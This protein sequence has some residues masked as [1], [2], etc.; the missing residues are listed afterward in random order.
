MNIAYITNLGESSLINLLSENFDEHVVFGS[1]KD[2]YIQSKK[3]S[4]ILVQGFSNKEF[5]GFLQ[6]I[7]KDNNYFLTP[8]FSK[9]KEY[10]LTCGNILNIEQC[11]EKIRVVDLLSKELTVKENLDWKDR[12]LMYLYTRKETILKPEIDD[13]HDIFYHYPLIEI[14]ANE[15]DNY[16]YY[17][18]SLAEQNV[19]Q[20]TTLVDKLFCCPKCF[21]AHLK[22]TDCCPNCNSINIKQAKF[23]HCFSCGFVAPEEKFEK[24]SRFVC[25]SC[26]AKLK[27]IGEDYD[28]PLES[29]VCNDCE[30]YYIDSK[31]EVTC[32]SEMVKLSSEDL[33]KRSI[34]EYK[35]TSFGL[36][37]IKYGIVNLTYL[38]V[39]DS[40]Y[41][42]VE[43]FNSIL[44]WFI[45]MNLRYQDE[46]FSMIA[47]KV[48]TLSEHINYTL[49]SELSKILRNMHRNTD[50]VVRIDNNIIV[51]I[52]PKVN[53]DGVNI[54]KTRLDEFSKSINNSQESLDI[55]IECFTSNKENVKDESANTLISNLISKL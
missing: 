32:I 41:V 9:E 39:D 10:E 23:I 37:Q 34:Y 54:I 21:S 3:F 36:N 47:I 51:F 14:F 12:F 15:E 45:Q 2:F 42:S 16:F 28:R 11:K 1:L 7:R 31:I 26:N 50:F 5:L 18:D 33:I 4:S 8:V 35:L 55:K 19:I 49:L 43:Y 46:I 53:S 27:L 22:F 30:E 6:V 24:N 29:G 13:S 17:L 44:S 25:P 48:M 20:K 38:I 52:Y 40:N